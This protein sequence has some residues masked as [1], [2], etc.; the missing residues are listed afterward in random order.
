MGGNPGTDPYSNWPLPTRSLDEN[1]FYIDD[2]NHITK[3][4]TRRTD[5]ESGNIWI[6]S[7]EDRR[8][9]LHYP[10]QNVEMFNDIYS[11]LKSAIDPRCDTFGGS[12]RTVTS[13]VIP[14]GDRMLHI[15][16]VEIVYDEPRESGGPIEGTYLGM[17]VTCK[18]DSANGVMF[19]VEQTLFGENEERVFLALLYDFKATRVSEPP[20]EMLVLFDQK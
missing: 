15:S 17:D 10:T 1:W 2:S 12:E 9:V 3:A 7:W 20:A 16:T 5:L 8:L 13:E 19:S 11:T 14:D 6:S 4:L 18:R